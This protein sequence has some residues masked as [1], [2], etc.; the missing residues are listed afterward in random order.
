M[1][2]VKSEP[3]RRLPFTPMFLLLL[4]LL[5]GCQSTAISPAELE[6]R[7]AAGREALAGEAAGLA[8]FF[9]DLFAL[10]VGAATRPV[11]IIQLGD[12]HTA[13]DRFSGRL[14][15]LFQQQFGAAGRGVLPPGEPFP[16]FRPT[17]VEIEQS[18]GWVAL[19]SFPN[20]S[21]GLFG[22]SGYRLIGGDAEDTLVL[23][24]TE[25]AGFSRLILGVV[26][27][28][29]GGTFALAVD[30][31][32]IHRQSTRAEQVRAGQLEMPAPP[33]SR[34]MTLT[35]A[36]DGPVELLF[37]GIER[38]GPGV[39]L[40]S[41]GVVGAS[42]AIIES[43]D[44]GTVRWGLGQRD[45]ALV[46]LAYGTNEAFHRD[47]DLQAYAARVDRQLDLVAEAVPDAAILVVGPPDA[48][49]LPR[50]CWGDDL[51]ET[52]LD[53]ACAPLTAEERAN[54]A[55]LFGDG[56]RDPVCRWHPPPDLASV[57]DILRDRAA[58]HGHMFWDWS[59]VMEGACGTHRW[60]A[61]DP[62]LAFF[63]HV[64]LQPE[65]YALSADRLFAF[66]ME[67]YARFRA[68]AGS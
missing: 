58:A 55:S 63:D 9:A 1:L 61:A 50:A 47:L 42:I 5:A 18:A 28:P 45:P 36:G 59:T 67:H 44:T 37:W 25:E 3:V 34:Q 23:R 33:G 41:H 56:V 7:E 32:E 38:P 16:F 15:A 62:P 31:Q 10:E 57:R 48:N 60:A 49:R 39:V 40:D 13:G 24:S 26:L 19:P 22:H 65:G 46:I 66:L 54:Y 12:S 35:A 8:P 29:S 51:R 21:G 17:L 6:A 2:W 64:H 43:W 20:P 4:A 53:Y 27:H 11:V 30:G 52:A 68:A 14:R